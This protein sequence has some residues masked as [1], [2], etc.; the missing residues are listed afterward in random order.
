M[1]FMESREKLGPQVR[2]GA[3]C[4]SVLPEGLGPEADRAATSACC[5]Q[6]QVG[7]TTPTQVLWACE[8][9]EEGKGMY[10]KQE[11]NS[12]RCMGGRRGVTTSRRVLVLVD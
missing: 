12:P 9:E 3:V 7:M 2:L 6:R 4:W 5:C 8:R 11:R 1:Q 10:E